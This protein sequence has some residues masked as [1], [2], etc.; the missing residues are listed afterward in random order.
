MSA[1]NRKPRAG[2]GTSDKSGKEADVYIHALGVA[3][4]WARVQQLFRAH[5]IGALDGKL[6]DPDAVLPE[7][8]KAAVDVE[9]AL[10]R[11]FIALRR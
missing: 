11:L 8:Y 5:F 4:Q 10:L 3:E 2:N 1:T 9:H 7:M 6:I